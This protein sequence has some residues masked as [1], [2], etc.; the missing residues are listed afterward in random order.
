MGGA[1]PY[2]REEYGTLGG[3]PQLLQN[4]GQ[5]FAHFLLSYKYVIK[6]SMVF[7]FY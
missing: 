6:Y 1:C 2:H 5:T 3:E 7:Y 4:T